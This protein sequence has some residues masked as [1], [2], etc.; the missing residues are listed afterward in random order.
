LATNMRRSS[1]CW[2]CTLAQ[3][4][5]CGACDSDEYPSLVPGFRPACCPCRDR[6][7]RFSVGQ[8][9]LSR[10]LAGRVSTESSGRLVRR[11]CRYSAVCHRA[12]SFGCQDLACFRLLNRPKEA[13]CERRR[14]CAPGSGPQRFLRCEWHLAESRKPALAR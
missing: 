8:I 2:A 7:H 11:A 4:I 12:C 1:T 9:G 6:R 5:I 3:P 13:R 14:C 10:V